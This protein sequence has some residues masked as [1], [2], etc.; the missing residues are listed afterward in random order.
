M[1]KTIKIDFQPFIDQSRVIIASDIV[2]IVAAIAGARGGKTEVGRRIVID[3]AIRQPGYLDKDRKEGKPYSIACWAPTFP[4]LSKI[5]IPAVLRGVPP[6]LVID[7]KKS[8]RELWM[9]G[10]HGT[11]QIY[12]LSGREPERSQGLQLYRGWIDECALVSELMFE[13][14]QTRLSDRRGHL[15]LTST[16]IGP[17]W[18]KKRVADIAKTEPE[19]VAF[20]SWRTIDN[21][22]FPKE[23]LEFKKRT[24]NPRYFKRTYEASFEAFEGMIFE[25]W[26]EEIHRLNEVKTMIHVW[27]ARRVLGNQTSPLRTFRVVRTIAGVDWGMTNPTVIMVIGV[28]DGNPADYILLDEIRD[29]GIL[30][31]GKGDTWVQR[32]QA[33]QHKWG[34]ST[35]WCGPDRPEN[36]DY[37]RRQGNLHAR[38]AEDDIFDGLQCMMNLMHPDPVTTLPHFYVWNAQG[39][40]DEI[41]IYQWDTNRLGMTVEKPVKAEDHSIDAARYAILSDMK[42]RFNREMDF[43]FQ[44]PDNL[45]TK[46]DLLRSARA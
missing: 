38:D 44:M 25:E 31:S 42:Y 1:S 3:W 28:T 39:F 16:P 12:F 27:P 35:F 8:D 17:N 33:L 15:I 18:V 36:I 13:E 14:A 43:R 41:A 30:V 46:W 7:Y 26:S 23:E 45:R 10:L 5:V 19:H 32:A 21:P 29:T 22:Y 6:E 34:I 20:F 11:T 40:V 24:M 2:R 4:M 9:H 37:F